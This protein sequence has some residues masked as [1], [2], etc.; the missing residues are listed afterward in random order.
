MDINIEAGSDYFG[1]LAA[2]ID[3]KGSGSMKTRFDGVGQYREFLQLKLEEC[4]N[5]G[6]ACGCYLSITNVT[7]AIFDRISGVHLEVSKT[8]RLTYDYVRQKL[9][10]RLMPGAAHEIV[11]VEF[12]RQITE[13]ICNIPGHTR[14]SIAGLG[15]TR[16]KVPGVG[17]KEGDQGLKPATRTAQ[18]DWPS[19][20]IEV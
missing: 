2:L 9:I 17:S 18:G 4:L 11:S 5:S 16:F 8:S 13:S 10:V 6:P 19:L 20:V 12:L 15:A 1:E 14:F 7:P 3:S